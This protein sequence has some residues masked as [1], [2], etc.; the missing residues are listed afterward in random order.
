MVL[1]G[2]NTC[3][4]ANTFAMFV[5]PYADVQQQHWKHYRRGNFCFQIPVTN[6]ARRPWIYSYGGWVF[7]IHD[8]NSTQ[9]HLGTQK[10]L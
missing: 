1:R 9:S 8:F 10:L 3:H 5:I 7:I 2:E 6:K 4:F